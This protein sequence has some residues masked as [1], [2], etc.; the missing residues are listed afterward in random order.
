MKCDNDK[1]IYE[2]YIIN[3]IYVNKLNKLKFYQYRKIKQLNDWHDHEL[4]L[5]ENKS[6]ELK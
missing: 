6:K 3:L 1:F 4:E 2:K 5:I